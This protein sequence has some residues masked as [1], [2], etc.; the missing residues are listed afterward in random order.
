MKINE[1][2]IESQLQEGPLLNKLGSAVGKGVGTVAKGVGAVAGGIAG[3]GKAF[4]KGYSAGKGTVS[5]AGD[6]SDTDSAPSGGGTVAQ[7]APGSVTGKTPQPKPTGPV[8]APSQTPPK[9]KLQAAAPVPKSTAPDAGQDTD[10]GPVGKVRPGADSA[11]AANDTQYAQAQKAIAAL[12]QEDQK[13]ILITLRS[14]PKVKAAMAQGKTKSTAQPAAPYTG[15]NWDAETGAPLS[16]KA[17]AEYEKFTPAQKAEIEKNIADKQKQLE[18]TGTAKKSKKKVSPSQAEIDADRAR[19]MGPTSDSVIRTG[20]SIVESID[21]AG[22]MAKLG[23]KVG[24]AAQSAGNVAGQ[25][26]GAVQHVKADPEHARNLVKAFATGDTSKDP[27]SASPI[28][29]KSGTV[30]KPII[31]KINQLNLEQRAELHKLITQKT[32]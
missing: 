17:K 24:Q 15:P 16:P 19:I 7:A 13:R 6:D 8:T 4:K 32:L 20:K 10:L 25:A 2:L 23:S 29:D 22:L 5:G 26:V 18:P 28:E 30:P 12:A 27:N 31:D 1:I 9:N 21:E 14:D 11:P 3:L